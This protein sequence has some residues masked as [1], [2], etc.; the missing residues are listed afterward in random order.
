MS[1]SVAAERSAPASLA[2]WKPKVLLVDDDFSVRESL[3]LALQSEN[4]LVVP[5]SNGQEAMDKYFEGY[6]DL[7]LLDLNIPEKIG[8]DIFERLTALNPYLAVILVTGRLDQRDLAAVTGASAVMEKP[9][10]VPLLVQDADI[11][12]QPDDKHV[13]DDA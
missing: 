5:A 13:E 7:V 3:R 10:N 4:F 8:W 12:L 6:V 1:K 9:L 11:Q 2:T